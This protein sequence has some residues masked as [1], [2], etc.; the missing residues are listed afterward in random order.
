MIVFG[1]L[2]RKYV[3]DELKVNENKEKCFFEEYKSE[4]LMIIID[5]QIKVTKYLKDNKEKKL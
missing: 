4:D 3:K 1:Q 2:S 5:T